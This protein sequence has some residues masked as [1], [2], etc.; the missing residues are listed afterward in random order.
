VPLSSILFAELVYGRPARPRNAIENRALM[1]LAEALSAPKSA[2]IQS[3]RSGVG[4]A[5]MRERVRHLK[6]TMDNQSEMEGTNE[7]VP[8]VDGPVLALRPNTIKPPSGNFGFVTFVECSK[9]RE[10]DSYIS[11]CISTPSHP[12][13]YSMRSI[14]A[15]RPSSRAHTIKAIKMNRLSFLLREWWPSL[16][17]WGHRNMV[18]GLK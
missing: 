3:N 7:L 5:G 11:L 16:V 12:G 9:P 8:L 2:L 13:Q 17:K 10:S 6:G 4:V 14:H 18:F 1:E 15:C